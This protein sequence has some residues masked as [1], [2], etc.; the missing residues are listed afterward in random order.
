MKMDPEHICH[1]ED[2]YSLVLLKQLTSNTESLLKLC[3]NY[4]ESS[5]PSTSSYTAVRLSS[6]SLSR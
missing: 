4:Q 5:S 6:L 1:Y 3:C 2:E